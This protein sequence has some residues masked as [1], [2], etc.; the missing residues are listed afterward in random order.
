MGSEGGGGQFLPSS[1]FFFF[2]FRLL[3]VTDSRTALLWQNKC[4]ILSHIHHFPLWGRVACGERAGGGG[5]KER[6]GREGKAPQMKI[7]NQ[8]ALLLQLRPRRGLHLIYSPK[9]GN[10]AIKRNQT[11][12][13]PAL[14]CPTVWCGQLWIRLNPLRWQ[15][16][17]R[18][19]SFPC[20]RRFM[21]CHSLPQGHLGSVLDTPVARLALTPSV[22][23][24]AGY[25]F[26]M[27]NGRG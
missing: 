10:Q 4:H 24:H 15:A 12:R 7:L 14:N 9:P 23:V 17:V 25:L 8:H 22:L 6:A 3:A 13:F 26:A 18:D 1:F 20:P 21:C 16:S 5:W 19:S 2:F 27:F 11:I